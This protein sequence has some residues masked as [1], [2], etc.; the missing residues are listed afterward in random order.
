MSERKLAR[1]LMD[2]AACN[3]HV[4]QKAAIA[5]YLRILSCYLC[6]VSGLRRHS[7]TIGWMAITF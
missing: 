3:D 1:W 5:R 6:G 2:L 4:P 7:I